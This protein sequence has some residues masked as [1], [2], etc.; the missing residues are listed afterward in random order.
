MQ[1]KRGLAAPLWLANHDVF[2]AFV[3]IVQRIP[4]HVY[5]ESTDRV[6]IGKMGLQH[7]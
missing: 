2:G 5:I 7:G 6:D 1:A 4:G 3:D